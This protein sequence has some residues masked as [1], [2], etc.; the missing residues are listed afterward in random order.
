MGRSVISKAMA[1]CAVTMLALGASVFVASAPAGALA[2]GVSALK[3]CQSPIN[4][5]DAYSCEFELSNTVQTSHNAV[6]TDQLTDVVFASGGNQ[7][8]TIPINNTTPG[9]IFTGGASCRS[10]EHTSELQS[11]RHLV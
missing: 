5:G 4:V 2:F 1:T 6:T 7:T 10:E 8:T 9:L 3:D 11:L